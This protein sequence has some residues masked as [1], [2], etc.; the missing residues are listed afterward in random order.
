MGHHDRFIRFTPQF[1]CHVICAFTLMA[2]YLA[3]VG[4]G[5]TRVHEETVPMLITYLFKN[6]GPLKLDNKNLQRS[7]FFTV[8][9]ILTLKK[10][11]GRSGQ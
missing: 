8:T 6:S 1:W 5:V 9:I 7:F 4:E 11:R 2:K 10:G 3:P